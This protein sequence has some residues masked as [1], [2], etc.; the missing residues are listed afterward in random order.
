VIE[1]NNKKEQNR[2]EKNWNKTGKKKKYKN[3]YISKIT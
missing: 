3:E 2:K 1:N